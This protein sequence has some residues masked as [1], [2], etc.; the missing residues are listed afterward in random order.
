[1][2]TGPPGIGSPGPAGPQGPPGQQSLPNLRVPVPNIITNLVSSGDVGEYT[3]IT[4]GTDGLP[5]ISYADASTDLAVAHCNDISCTSAT[6]TSLESGPGLRGLHTSIAI[7]TDGLPIISYVFD[8]SEMKI[9]HC[10]DISCTS[11]QLR[12]IDSGV[13]TSTSITIG[14]DGLPVFSYTEESPDNLK[15]GHCDDISCSTSSIENLPNVDSQGHTSIAIGIDGLPIISYDILIGGVN[16]LGIAHCTDIDC[17]AP[18]SISG[19]GIPGS[20]LGEFTSI[21][22]GTDG[23][24]II[25]YRDANQLG[26]GVAHCN[27]IECLSVSSS[28]IDSGNDVGYYTSITIGTDGLPII[29]YY[30]NTHGR[31]KIAHCG[32]EACTTNNVAIAVDGTFGGGIDTGLHTSIVIGVDGLPIISYYEPGTGDLKTIK[33]ANNFFVSNWVRR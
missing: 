20:N 32:D 21:T 11:A 24:P 4:I 30:D 1:M 14:T 8:S 12:T 26:L 13:F 22:I 2:Q 15:V 28:N 18:P 25:S 33:G 29:S 5:I 31:L 6:T 7:G 10:D 17:S 9:A 27:D 3:S 19:V 16:G 23:L